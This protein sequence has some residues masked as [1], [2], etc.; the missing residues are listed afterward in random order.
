M[1][2]VPLLR[3]ALSLFPRLAHSGLL[4]RN[5]PQFPRLFHQDILVVRSRPRKP[6]PR[7]RHRKRHHPN[8]SILLAI[9]RISLTRQKLSLRH[10]LRLWIS[11]DR[12]LHLS[13]N[14]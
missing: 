14:V 13:R 2:L 7:R 12:Q 6:L 1:P 9:D 11:F 10:S 3:L 8:Q 4:P 5:P